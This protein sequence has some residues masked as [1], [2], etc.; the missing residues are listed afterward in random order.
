MKFV[1][2]VVAGVCALGLVGGLAADVQAASSDD[3]T[4]PC[5]Q[6][7]RVDLSL[8]A[9][10]PGSTEVSDT[11]TSWKKDEKISTLV[12]DLSKRRISIEDAKKMID[13]EAA[14]LTGDRAAQL[15]MIFNGLFQTLNLERKSIVAGIEKYSLSQIKLAKKVTDTALEVD[16]LGQ[17]DELSDEEAEKIDKLNQQLVWDTRIYDERTQSLEYVCES[18]VIIEQRLFALAKEIA[19]HIK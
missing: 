12:K 14:K 17:K 5:A 2:L 18:P 13:E 9:I 6:R 19:K 3:K 7:K 4:W 1:K 10:W 8:G 15:T 16:L 11:D